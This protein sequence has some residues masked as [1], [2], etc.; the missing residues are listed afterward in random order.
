MNIKSA[1]ILIVWII[2]L[3]SVPVFSQLFQFPEIIEYNIFKNDVKTPEKSIFIFEKLGRYI[4]TSNTTFRFIDPKK[5]QINEIHTYL[6]S[7]DYSYQ[8]SIVRC[9]AKKINEMSLVQGKGFDQSDTMMIKFQTDKRTGFEPLCKPLLFIDINTALIVSAHAAFMNYN[10]H[11]KCYFY[12]F[13]DSKLKLAKMHLNGTKTIQNNGKTM[14]CK[15]FQVHSEEDD[16]II[17]ILI[18]KDSKGYCIPAAI[19]WK[20]LQ[21]KFHINK[22][23]L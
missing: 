23:V 6:R 22:I 21:I 19:S 15:R 11:T 18:Y 20:N 9:N 5:K 3:N 14:L 16:E 2:V 4:G 12:S 10:Y 7:L 13:T 8:S 17:D 1:Q